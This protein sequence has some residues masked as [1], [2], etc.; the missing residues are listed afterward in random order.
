MPEIILHAMNY[1][2]NMSV[3][4]RIICLDNADVAN[5]FRAQKFEKNS[6]IR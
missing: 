1:F 5:L 4:I 3:I 6:K 2:K